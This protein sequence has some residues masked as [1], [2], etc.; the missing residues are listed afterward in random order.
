MMSLS[1]ALASVGHSL[2][3]DD[4][5]SNITNGLGDAYE[6]VIVSITSRVEPY[7]ISEV[8][9]LLLAH[10]KRIESYTINPDGSTPYANL[11]FNNGHKK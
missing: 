8:T 4:K 9:V 11:A 6:S 7:T 1:D 10:E 5:V 3:E 2:Y